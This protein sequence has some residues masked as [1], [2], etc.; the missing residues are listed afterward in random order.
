MNDNPEI[1]SI[2]TGY[3][4][5]EISDRQ[6]EILNEWLKNPANKELFKSYAKANYL[7]AATPYQ[8]EEKKIGKLRTLRPLLSI[9]AVLLLLLSAAGIW[10]WSLPEKQAPSN[11]FVSVGINGNYTVLQ[12]VETSQSIDDKNKVQ[13]AKVEKG[14]LELL[15]NS[16]SN[17]MTVHVPN[18]KNLKVLLSDGSEILLNAGTRL[19]FDAD[20]GKKGPREVSL[21]GQAFFH[22]ASDKAHPFYVK[23]DEFTTKVLGTK[24][25][26]S[27]YKNERQPYVNLVEGS[28]AVQG[29]SGTSK[30][31]TPG[32]KMTFIPEEKTAIV[33]PARPVQDMDWL[34]REIA[35]DNNTTD[36]V[37]TKIERVYGL[38][39]IRN[40]V[41]VENFHFSGTFK[42][43]NL[44]EITHSLEVLLNC[45]IRKDGHK[46]ILLSKN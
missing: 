18:G 41:E 29:N 6:R 27:S 37:L 31:L 28:I 44:D 10:R 39:I 38:Q 7:A 19:S 8:E 34:H 46:L 24:F 9:A 17:E 3:F 16:S 33:Q 11:E 45:K 1:F 25:N 26:V 32:Q 13:L 12:D 43:E 14:T 5:G 4:T 30:V 15:R 2:I 42:I 40:R 36:E 35:F 20:F 21:S 22:V 23:T